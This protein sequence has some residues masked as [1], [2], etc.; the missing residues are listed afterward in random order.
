M[1]SKKN[2]KVAVGHP[3][4][5]VTGTLFHE[6]EDYVLPGQM[7]LVFGRRYS[8]ALAG[9]GEGMFG[10]GWTSPL[11][12]RLCQDLE[13]FRMV[14][15]DGE[16]EVTFDDPDDDVNSGGVVRNLGVFCELRREGST[17]TV[18][19]W[20]PNRDDVTQY[21]FREH[22]AGE[23]WHLVSRQNLEGQGIDIEH[24]AAGRVIR[25]KQRR[26]R[27]GLRLVYN[28]SGR[29]TEVYVMV[30]PRDGA[31]YPEQAETS[32]RLI[33]RFDYDQHGF[34]SEM[35][36]ALQQNCLYRYTST[37][38][39][40]QE[41][42]LSGMVYQFAYD[43]KGRCIETKGT[44]DYGLV[45]LEIHAEAR[46]TLATDSLGHVTTYEW[47]DNGQV[48]RERSPL[49]HVKATEYDQHRRI[50]KEIAPS[51]AV[52]LHEFDAQGN[53]VKITAPS[54]A[55]THFVYNASHRITQITDPAGSLWRREFDDLGRLKEII[56][57][58][59]ERLSYG[60][61]Q[62]NDLVWIEDPGGRRCGF[63]WD[64]AGNLTSATDWQ[65]NRTTFAYNREGQL[66][67]MVDPLGHRTEVLVDPLG[68]IQTIHLADGA[69]RSFAWDAYD[70]PIHYVDA[71]G[72]T[73]RWRYARYGLLA[74]VMRPHGGSIRFL[75][76]SIPG[77][78][79]AVINERGERY[80]LQ[81]DAD[82][83][84]IREVNFAGRE[85]IYAYDANGQVV[86][87]V[88]P[89]GHRTVCQRNLD[90]AVTHIAYDDGS[91]ITYEYDVKGRLIKADNG[92]CL[93]ERTY[94]VADRCI[95]EKQGK[96]EIHSQYDILGNR[97]KRRSSLGYETAFA[98]NASGQLDRLTAG[99]AAPIQFVYDACWNE[100]ARFIEGAVQ[101]CQDYDSRGRRVEQYVGRHQY[102]NPSRVS[103]RQDA[104]L[105]REYRYDTA[106]NLIEILD[107]DWGATKYLY[108][109]V[110][111]IVETRLPEGV[112]ERFQY[113][114][115]DNLTALNRRQEGVPA[116]FH[117]EEAHRL[118]YEAGNIL[119][120][121]GE[122]AYTYDT[123]GQRVTKTD[124]DGKTTRYQWNP[125][126]Q[127]SQV[128]LPDG[129]QWQYQYDALNRR[130][131]KIGPS[132]TIE[133][134]WDGP[135]VLHEV[136]YETKGDET[137]SDQG[138]SRE[139]S[140]VHWE[141]DPYGFEPIAKVEHR[142]LFLCV[143]DAA[144]NPR[145]LID[146][147]GQVAW[148]AQFT[149]WGE[150]QH[151]RVSKVSC[152]VRF[153]GQWYDEET[154][155]HYNRLR[156]YDPLIGRFIS[157]DP[158]GLLGGVN[159]FV[160][161]V[162][163]TGW[164]DPYGLT[165]RCP[166]TTEEDYVTIQRVEQRSRRGGKY[167]NTRLDVDADGQVVHIPAGKG[168]D[169]ALHVSID[170]EARIRQFFAQ[171]EAARP[172][173][174]VIR[175]FQVP[176]S[177]VERMTDNA[178]PQ[179]PGTSAR[180]GQPLSVDQPHPGQFAF[181]PDDADRLAAHARPGSFREWTP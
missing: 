117:A 173:A 123:V 83:N 113:D 87:V 16:T 44:D 104:I 19:R 53:R 168:K 38:K 42:N 31:E 91:N 48:E 159:E 127:L 98:W 71:L 89:A 2:G 128:I 177:V 178:I 34:L 6:F 171:R 154:G 80:S 147:T 119:I 118:Q 85:T 175:E 72:S 161:A 136:A 25:L 62:N 4:D 45:R 20:D 144:G 158:I 138:A 65:G 90:G 5:V 121:R 57:P 27:R 39:M 58:L 157:P 81:Y 56:N 41:T 22:G 140:I 74:E 172:G 30:P 134:V 47:N 61:D 11:E 3:V 95:S 108:D 49:G 96:Y 37:G 86:A 106:S 131:K 114:E 174:N 181:H 69:R 126:G 100:T 55:E 32:E 166:T 167:G 64:R 169:P 88:D 79:L 125:V 151:C 103:E 164:V 110:S 152:P 7:P 24:D 97:V 84:L 75:W 73:T 70:Q 137:A 112:V 180:P 26:E 66:T 13:G 77:Q 170:N 141:F 115:T 133:F 82:G 146:S 93:V 92:Q 116:G 120:R 10:P 139:H 124:Q 162:N 52:M 18:T 60:Y 155:L 163:P 50:V 99:S 1:Q 8:S 156:Y 35:I 29:V 67:T 51:G 78:L 142:Q 54:G 109:P 160:Y 59:G 76:S 132:Q 179:G 143:N 68:R 153:Q 107:K 43:A 135:R 102:G 145:E 21:V 36:D 176:R 23:W 33:L 130:V 129:Q 15:E 17:Y 14:D 40:V 165:R 101:I 12:M 94:D 122:T 148:S 149:T 63:T 105:R 46:V 28:A 9:Q 111:R 150:V